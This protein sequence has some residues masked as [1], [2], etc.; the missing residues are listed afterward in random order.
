MFFVALILLMNILEPTVLEG[1]Y[2][3][4][5]IE[6]KQSTHGKG[7][8]ATK[9]LKKFTCIPILGHVLKSSLDALNYKSHYWKM[10]GHGKKG[11]LIDGHPS[12][13]TDGR[14]IGMMLNEPHKGGP[15]CIFWKDLVVTIKPLKVGTELFVYYGSMYPRALFNYKLTKSVTTKSQA[16]SDKV[17]D[18]KAF[19]IFD[20]RLKTKKVTKLLTDLFE[21]YLSTP[22]EENPQ[23]LKD[24]LEALKNRDTIIHDQKI[25]NILNHVAFH[26]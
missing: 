24:V 2:N 14:N 18:S 22:H 17:L 9:T 8:F 12:I 13:N 21:K 20:N 10:A 25:K 5:G 11:T 4:D 7:V 23:W 6:V 3:W 1:K 16:L 26:R 19:E 15:N